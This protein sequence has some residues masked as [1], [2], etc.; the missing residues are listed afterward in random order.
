MG[1]DLDMIEVAAV[2]YF[3]KTGAP[4]KRKNNGSITEW[5]LNNICIGKMNYNTKK[6]STFWL[7]KK[8][9]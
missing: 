6:G 5:W 1:N 8:Y 2:D 4:A 7:N 9:V 3:V